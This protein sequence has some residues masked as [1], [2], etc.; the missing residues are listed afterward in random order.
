MCALKTFY[1]AVFFISLLL[2]HSF[3]LAQD[4]TVSGIVKNTSGDA[5]QSA[6]VTLVN[7]QSTIIR[8]TSTNAQ[9]SYSLIIPQTPAA[10]WLE[11]SYI[12]YKR[13]RLAVQEGQ[14]IYQF[15]L[16][17]DTSMLSEVVIKKRP[18]IE[19]SGDTLRYYVASFA[20]KED[21]S[22][23]DVL[24]RMPGIEVD[25][26]GT[27][28]HNG[29]KIE[30]LYIQGD[31]LMD[32]R[33]GLA[34]KV[35]RKEMILSVDVIRNHQPIEVLKDKII[36]DKTSINLVLKS[37]NSLKLSANAQVGAGL[38]KQYDLSFTPILLNKSIKMINTLATN[39]R[40]VDYRNDFKQLGANNMISSINNEQPDISLS[41]GTI[42]PPDLPLANYY[43]NRS[44]LVN[45]NNIYNTKKGVQLKV[46]IQG[47]MDK[48]NMDYF[49]QVDNYLPNDTISY[50]EQQSFTNKP[51]LLNTSFNVMI[52]RKK[53]FF[54]NSTKVKLSRDNNQSF[55]D[56]N[57]RSF[58]QSLSKN[59]SEFSNDLNWIPSIRG[60]GVGE[61]RWL[62]N[63]ARNNQLLDIGAGYYSEI[64]EHQD[65]YDHVV[66]RL[67]A[68]VLFSNAYLGYRIPANVINQEYKIGFLSELQQLQ[69]ALEFSKNQQTMPYSGDAGNDLQWTRKS[70]YF[71]SQ[72]EIKYKKI[73]STIQLPLTYQSIR[74]NQD[75]YNMDSRN[76]R[77]LFN[78]AVN[79]T[80]NINPEQYFTARYKYANSFAN[81]T[82]VYRG[83]ILLN[84]RT[85][86][87]NDAGVQERASHSSSL[88]YNFQKS[89]SMLFAN[90]G[91]SYDKSISQALLSTDFAN[92]IQKIIFLP[93]RNS[94]TNLM[95]TSGISKYSFP[96][97]STLSLK[98]GWSKLK[99][100][101]LINNG[102]IPFQS[103]SL[104]LNGSVLKKIMEKVSISYQPNSLWTST[105][106]LQEIRNGNN[107]SNRT[108]RLDQL[109][110]IGFN[111]KNKIQFEVVNRHSYSRQSN[112]NDVRYF[113]MDGQVRYTDTKKRLDLNLFI[114]NMFNVRDYTLYSIAANQLVA[115]QYRLR[116]RMAIVRLDFYF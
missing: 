54:N 96:L 4:R 108:F 86:R 98:A 74:Y 72:Y 94:R 36:S 57:G 64:K 12:G 63:Y 11:V 77:L 92:N 53:Y 59:T 106:S 42:G 61:L 44:A 56:F 87:A 43:F 91:V 55:M 51:M 79:F 27:I 26:D 97:K 46:N 13:Q 67:E 48:N 115:D 52:N 89:I 76:R 95:L 45:L 80:Y 111:V 84:Y 41:L 1:Y 39:N 107:L 60:K 37:E 70:I 73:R 113:F 2:Y 103:N 81:I 10:L 116:G 40:G 23:R 101:Q 104:F 28:Y 68:P 65:F 47:Y 82:G 109:L 93:Y 85:L 16:S 110:T 102:L 3:V 75:E 24:R 19:F 21:R 29:K 78:P 90:A 71:S 58:R 33:Y 5:L 112:N 17:P 6:S 34:T 99:Y 62:I 14:S 25:A 35:I 100:V 88:Y 7:D 38:P 30:N 22:I 15:S 83:A 114:T 31:D 20:N 8:F 32:G 49:S 66:Q 105:R 69:S 9:G 50:R 18:I